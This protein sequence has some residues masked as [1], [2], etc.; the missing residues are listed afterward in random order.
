MKAKRV[1]DDLFRNYAVRILEPLVFEAIQFSLNMFRQGGSIT[2]EAEVRGTLECVHKC[3]AAV[4]IDHCHCSQTVEKEVE[5]L[6]E[7]RNTL[8]ATWEHYKHSQK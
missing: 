1:S 3:R 5:E 2:R 4:C 7:C 8:A 6:R